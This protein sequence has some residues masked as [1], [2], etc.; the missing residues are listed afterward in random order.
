[1]YNTGSYSQIFQELDERA[2]VPR[3]LNFST[4]V[5]S[6]EKLKNWLYKV[7]HNESAN[8]K[9]YL[10]LLDAGFNKPVLAK[11]LSL[12]VLPGKFID[13][14]FILRDD[15]NKG[16]RGSSGAYGLIFKESRITLSLYADVEN[17]YIRWS[18]RYESTIDHELT[19]AFQS[20]EVAIRYLFLKNKNIPNYSPSY[21][22]IMKWMTKVNVKNRSYNKQFKDKKTDPNVYVKYL[23]SD[24]EM[25]AR[26]H[27]LLRELYKR[28]RSLFNDVI[29]FCQTGWPSFDY[30]NRKLMSD[31]Y[32]GWTELTSLSRSEIETFNIREVE[33]YGYALKQKLLDKLYDFYTT[34]YKR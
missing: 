16:P 12:E 7:I 33:T 8:R 22:D 28:N 4:G 24:R 32:H 19:H 23:A 29:E 25:A 13:V 5:K 30:I 26:A 9:L 1:M 14:Y 15:P 21:D 6:A 11:G 27:A 10:R 3:A 18:E 17:D 2:S 20:M 34:Q 31:N